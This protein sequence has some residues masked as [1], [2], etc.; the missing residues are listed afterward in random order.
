MQELCAVAP[1]NRPVLEAAL[2]LDFADSEDGV[3][4]EA[5][6]LVDTEAIVT[7]NPRD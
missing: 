4:H 2:E 6:R 3:L 5:A 7:R 1:V